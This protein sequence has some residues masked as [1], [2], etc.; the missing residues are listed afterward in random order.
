MRFSL[1]ISTWSELNHAYICFFNCP[2]FAWSV[3]TVNL[4]IECT[5]LDTMNLKS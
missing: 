3:M 1:T 5:T 2:L 4:S